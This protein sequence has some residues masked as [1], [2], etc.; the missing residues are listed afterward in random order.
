MG[1][2][3]KFGLDARKSKVTACPYL[4]L[5][6]RS[7]GLQHL[8]LLLLQCNKEFFLIFAGSGEVGAYLKNPDDVL[9]FCIVG[10]FL[11]ENKLR[12]LR[13][14]ENRVVWWELEK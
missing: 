7:S 3:L 8:L 10:S 12:M 1:E 5:Q 9:E 14:I 13:K 11:I 6:F 4:I 2:S